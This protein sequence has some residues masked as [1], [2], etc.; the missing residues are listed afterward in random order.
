MR[1]GAGLNAELE[2]RHSLRCK[3]LETIISLQIV[4]YSVVM[5][6]D[7]IIIQS[8]GK[9]HFPQDCD[10][11][12]ATSLPQLI[13]HL[14]WMVWTEPWGSALLCSLLTHF[15]GSSW[16]APSFPRAE[17]GAAS[18]SPAPQVPA[19]CWRRRH[20]CGFSPSWGVTS[21]GS[22]RSMVRSESSSSP[23]RLDQ[24]LHWGTASP[25]QG[26]GAL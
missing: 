6:I 5:I 4:N 26:L 12:E 17:P 9:H 22:T 25:S 14:L 13:H 2:H 23:I 1:E 16:G 21:P 11:D 3:A 10:F 7:S 8:A 15:S 20:D 18:T 24:T 19:Q